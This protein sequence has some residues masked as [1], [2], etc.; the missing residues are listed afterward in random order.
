MLLLLLL[1]LLLLLSLLLLLLPPL[2]LLL[3][4]LGHGALFYRGLSRVSGLKN[5]GRRGTHNFKGLK[6][7]RGITSFWTIFFRV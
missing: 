6:M 3:L 7:A 2:L 5:T 4:L 1:Q